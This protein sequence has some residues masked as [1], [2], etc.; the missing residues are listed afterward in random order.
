LLSDFSSFMEFVPHE[1]A[2]AV[3]DQET[4]QIVWGDGTGAN[5]TGILNTS[6]VL[7]RTVGTDTEIDASSRASTT[8]ASVPASPRLISW[9]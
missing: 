5:M 3:I 8:S 1:L 7:T 4:A 2:R 6:G 9:R